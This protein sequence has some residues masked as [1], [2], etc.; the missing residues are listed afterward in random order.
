MGRT[1][2]KKREKRKDFQK[3]KLRVGK[4]KQPAV[5]ATN[6]NFRSQAIHI[7]EQ[8]KTDSSQP[9]NRRKQTVQELFSHLNHYNSSIRQDS[10][11]GLKDLFVQH[12]Q[13][14]S[15]HLS[16][17]LE[18]VS[19]LFTDSEH[20]VRRTAIGLLQY[21]F[22][23]LSANQV[24]PFF[25]ILNSHLCCAMTHIFEDI[26]FD[27][28][29]VLDLVLQYFPELVTKHSNQLVPNFV[30]QISK[31]SGAAKSSRILTVNPSS[32]LSSQKWRR[33]VLQRLYQFLKALL[34]SQNKTTSL[35]NKAGQCI[36]KWD[37]MKSVHVQVFSAPE[38]KSTPI[39]TLRSTSRLGKSTEDE[40][41]SR[42]EELLG[43][44]RN[45]VPILL[46]IWVEANPENQLSFE[47]M[48]TFYGIL[49]ILQ[50]LWRQMSDIST[51]EDGCM[52][53]LLSSHIKDF[54][55][56]L[57]TC[58]PYASHEPLQTRKPQKVQSVTGVALN[59]CVCEVMSYFI[60]EGNS[61]EKWVKSLVDYVCGILREQKQI[62][63]E[64]L[65]TILQFI[66]RL[67]NVLKNT[68]I[69]GK[70]VKSL[71][72][73]YKVCH[74]L[75][76]NKRLVIEF[77][78]SLVIHNVY[79]YK[80]TERFAVISKWLQG[81]PQLLL[82]IKTHCRSTT[83][84]ILHVMSV[85]ASQRNEQLMVCLQENVRQIVDPG[86][87][88]LLLLPTENQRQIIELLY[89]V[90]NITLETFIFLA[91]CCHDNRL[92]SENV[93]YLLQILFFRYQN[94]TSNMKAMNIE[95]IAFDNVDYLRFLFSVLLGRSPHK[96]VCGCLAMLSSKDQV[97]EIF[98]TAV[99]NY[100]SKVT[101]LPIPTL[102]AVLL[103]ILHLYPGNT[104]ASL[105]N[106]ELTDAI[107][108]CCLAALYHTSQVY[109]SGCYTEDSWVMNLVAMVTGVMV[110]LNEIWESF[111]HYLNSVLD[112]SLSEDNLRGIALII[113]K[114]LQTTE[115]NSRVKESEEIMQSI[116]ESIINHRHS[117]TNSQWIT[118]L[119]YEA[120]IRF[121]KPS[122]G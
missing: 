79:G 61:K 74:L 24:S 16:N 70:L 84:E 100:L 5:N 56:H 112:D 64:N 105:S 114:L 118:E 32:K 119:K 37:N 90:P 75:S 47:S 117:E 22:P 6:V 43:F 26:R 52:D 94:A 57:M 97:W 72:S 54:H 98:Q 8:L 1:A 65:Q 33:K 115:L 73:Y 113:I 49:S 89:H 51:S 83:T 116:I 31:S 78:S 71:Y 60:T 82:N 108:M 58:F 10:L 20:D 110:T 80:I 55:H 14:I 18:H 103:S 7:K 53:K 101:H 76:Q 86:Q 122:L 93:A 45:L 95:P 27:S 120:S 88:V 17:V 39:F 63:M 50:L 99:Q 104:D 48:E 59:L 77:F 66:R 67:L 42:P 35:N 21:I 2:R 11:L 3:V 96:A 36:V 107:V 44:I 38:P 34:E 41:L 87:G 19:S 40:Y 23:H 62:L 30:N 68:D 92:S 102:S 15:N 69:L 46:Q 12:P 13:Q 91:D 109:R 4:K 111:P 25:G 9:T 121:P 106:R 85:T 29:K 28:L 81:L